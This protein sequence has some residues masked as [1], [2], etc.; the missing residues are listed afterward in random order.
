MNKKH[1]ISFLVVM[2]F[3][4]FTQKVSA[5]LEITEIMYA[6]ENGSNYEWVEIYNSGTDSID[7][8]KYR[9]FHGETNSGPITLK[10]GSTTIL[11]PSE[12][13]IISKS[14]SEGY[15]WLNF[16]GRIF[17]AGTLSLPDSSTGEYNT[18]IAISDQNGS[19]IDDFKYDTSKGGSKISKTSLSKIQG[20]WQA[21]IPTPGLV[22]I[23]TSINN[24]TE[25]LGD[26]VNEDDN[27][28]SSGTSSNSSSSSTK[29]KYPKI[30]E[31]KTQIILP[32]IIVAGIP[33][34][35]K[36]LTTTN[37]DQTFS[38][39]KFIWNFG[40]GMS[41]ES[42]NAETFEY[43]YSYP[44]EYVL[45]LSFFDRYFNLKPDPEATDRVIVK[46][47]PPEIF[48]TSV[49]GG[50][51][52]FIELEN[53]SKSE[54]DISGWVLRGINNSFVLPNG[55]IILPSKKIKLSPKVTLFNSSDL[56][57]VILSNQV[58]E[59]IAI[60]PQKKTYSNV[61][62]LNS[63]NI[64]TIKKE[65]SPSVINLNDLSANA[66]N[67]NEN[68]VNSYYAWMG[69]LGVVVIGSISMILMRRRKIYP[70]YIDK[71][72][73]AEDMSIIE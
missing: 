69:L 67:S 52:L 42:K 12:Y 44:G 15:D 31:I 56:S 55:M 8:N 2:V 47:I 41:R 1:F 43:I 7:L 3:F 29:K 11:Q 35:M 70:D 60:Y 61:S 20:S 5:N 68:T 21:G 22:N 51:D 58:G 36:S 32:K 66:S 34:N 23:L 27:S 71:D 19:I 28:D 64:N 50:D 40:D 33:F 16:D 10:N 24:I 54:I 46:V 25:E 49:G 57:S 72:I 73:R 65:E 37:R 26:S 62:K 59:T 18:Y 38:V 13:F 45:T 4:I 30:L 6:P 48:I 63:N 53:K 9:F 14:L 17:S 39:G